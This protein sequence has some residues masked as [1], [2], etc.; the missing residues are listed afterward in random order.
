MRD[1][2]FVT[3]E[4]SKVEV[5]EI[6]KSTIRYFNDNKCTLPFMQIKLRE[7][8]GDVAGGVYLIPMLKIN[9]EQ[10]LMKYLYNTY[11]NLCGLRMGYKIKQVG[12]SV[13]PPKVKP[14]EVSWATLQSV[15]S[16]PVVE[17]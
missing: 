5:A 14:I 6:V 4:I 2:K 3:R 16:M 17:Q 8:L 13:A 1:G 15:A 9:K 7:V 12:C 10:D 11:L